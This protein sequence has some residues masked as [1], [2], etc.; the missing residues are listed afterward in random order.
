MAEGRARGALNK[1][2]ARLTS[3]RLIKGSVLETTPLR[4][5]GFAAVQEVRKWQIVAKVTEQ[6][7]WNSILKQSNRGGCAFESTLSVCARF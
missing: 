3:A 7:L 4:L 1:R 2:E 5:I 6:M